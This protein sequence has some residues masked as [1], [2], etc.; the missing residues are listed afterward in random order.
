[1]AALLP[2]GNIMHVVKKEVEPL[3]N[4]QIDAFRA[5]FC[6]G[7]RGNVQRLIA[8]YDALKSDLDEALDLLDDVYNN[9]ECKTIGDPEYHRTKCMPCRAEAI[10]RKHWRIE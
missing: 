4:E 1:M 6:E 7:K 8:S 10:L 2:K 9:C 3:T 5:G